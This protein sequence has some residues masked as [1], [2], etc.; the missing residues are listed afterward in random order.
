ME[1][2]KERLKRLSFY[3]HSLEDVIRAVMQVDPKPLWEEEK[4]LREEK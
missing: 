3:G 2:K 4:R 1:N